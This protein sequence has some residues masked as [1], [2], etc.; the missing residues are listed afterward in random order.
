MK[1]PQEKT[2]VF[3]VEVERL[4]SNKL[5]EEE[6]DELFDDDIDDLFDDEFDSLLDDDEDDDLDWL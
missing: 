4:P 5:T 6:I 3:E 2:E 1:N